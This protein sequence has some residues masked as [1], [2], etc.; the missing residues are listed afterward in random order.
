M[1]L[2]RTKPFKKDYQKLPKNIQELFDNKI[3]LFVNNFKHPSLRTHKIQGESDIWE[4]SI[5]MKYRFTFSL[6]DNGICI[7]RRVGAHDIIK[8]P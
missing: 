1:S 7:L 3:K 4:A 2:I 8:N 6:T 5:N